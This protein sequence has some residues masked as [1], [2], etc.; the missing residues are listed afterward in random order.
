MLAQPL[1]QVTVGLYVHKLC[2]HLPG[3]GWLPCFLIQHAKAIQFCGTQALD[4][5]WAWSFNTPVVKDHFQKLAM[6]LEKYNI[7]LK[8]VY[9][10]DEKGCQLSGRRKQSHRKYL[11]PWAS[12][13]SYRV[14][15]AN[16][17]L[18]AIVETVSADSYALKPYIIFKGKLLQEDWYQ[19]EGVDKVSMWVQIIMIR[20][21]ARP[22]KTESYTTNIG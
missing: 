11:L 21:L 2:G 3:K 7:P 9:N 20:L 13:E 10:M 18:V 6:L 22:H 8:N 1:S 15:D 16:L 19:A 4:P 17:E 14:W 12:H 5:K